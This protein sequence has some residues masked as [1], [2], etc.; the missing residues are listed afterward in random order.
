MPSEPYA[1]SV[2]PQVSSSGQVR[3]RSV[4]ATGQFVGVGP[5]FFRVNNRTFVEGV[6][7]DADGVAALSQ[8]A[9][10]DTKARDTLFTDGQDAIGQVILVGN[11]PVRVI[12]VVAG[13]HQQ[14]RAAVELDQRL[15]AL[16]HGDV[17]HPGPELAELDHRAHCRQ[18]RCHRGADPRSRH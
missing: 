16:H 2:T 18:C 7:F 3:Y 12:G 13:E 10:I 4:S 9:V 17:P 8:E 1:D 14:F 5:D 15:D 6:A 11:V